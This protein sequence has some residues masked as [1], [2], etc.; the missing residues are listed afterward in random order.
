MSGKALVLI[1]GLDEV[2]EEMRP[3]VRTWLQ[4][5]ITQYP[6]VRY[7]VTTRPHA[8]KGDWLSNDEFVDA[9]L[10]DMSR[11]DVATFVEH[12]HSAVASGLSDPVQRSNV[13][14]LELAL[15]REI[16]KS[17]DLTRLARSPL[18]CAMICALHRD[19]NEALPKNRIGLYRACVDMF[20]RRDNERKM[21]M[22]DYV[23]LE[24]E[25]KL[26]LLRSL[27]WWMIRN[28][29]S[30]ATMGEL[31][32]RFGHAIKELN[33]RPRDVTAQQAS[34]LF[35]ER[36]ALLQ[37]VS[38][39]KVN[40]P[41]RTFQEYL[42]AQEALAEGD[43][44]LLISHSEMESWREVTILAAGLIENKVEA[45]SF[46]KMIFERGDGSAEHQKTLYLTAAVARQYVSR[47]PEDSSLESEARRRLEKFLPP[48]S[49][50]S[51]QELSKA[52]TLV[53]PLLS[54][55]RDRAPEETAASL[56]TLA[57]INTPEAVAVLSDYIDDDRVEV[58][59][60][61]FESLQFLSDDLRIE[62]AG[63]I[64]VLKLQSSWGLTN[65]EGIEH[66]ST[67]QTLD[68]SSCPKLGHVK[69]LRSCKRLRN[70][71]LHFCASLADIS[72]LEG[73]ESLETLNLSNC[74]SLADIS[75]VAKCFSLQTLYLSSCK[76]L[77]D[78]KPL[79]EC[80]ALHTLYLNEC[81]KV[82][83][84]NALSRCASLQTL[85]LSDCDGAI[86]LNPLGKCHSLR[87]LC[88]SNYFCLT[89]IEFM[90]GCRELTSLDISNSPS[91]VDIKVLGSQNQLK[92]CSI[93]GCCF[94]TDI[95]PLEKCFEL[96]TL[97]LTDCLSLEEISSL[98]SCRS[99]QRLVARNCPK[100]A[101]TAFDELKE[102]LPSLVI[103]T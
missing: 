56:R 91:L 55:S 54:Y 47:L 20:C 86:D 34:R 73:C 3:H 41:H 74:L 87:T 25:H 33:P 31:D 94:L 37:L 40:F 35:I 95:S 50:E 48:K 14:R 36:V 10:R 76:N 80:Q 23:E 103:E 92:N 38:A 75:A 71:N 79:S 39:K 63:K 16:Q 97:N 81:P 66:C 22:P 64:R 44:Q 17:T 9:T 49:I 8:V 61:L 32:E 72:G 84:V 102:R 100:I 5:L 6:D 12:W 2:S 15:L 62:L 11:P 26:L 69:G 4:S 98:Q 24:D 93:K 13:K 78:L 101:P 51:A 89:D 42:A 27:A 46:V 30:V 19:R 52:G 7:V 59:K 60:Q 65:C 1:D 57:R 96:K 45:E 29:K 28:E 99:L 68:V 43:S 21:R 85:H 70:L 18:L 83:N 58:S 77:S 82:S 67:L 88:L 90:K 53:V